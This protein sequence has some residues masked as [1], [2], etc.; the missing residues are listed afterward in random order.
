M[1]SNSRV[2]SSALLLIAIQGAS[3]PRLSLLWPCRRPHSPNDTLCCI[4]L[5]HRT[6]LSRTFP[7]SDAARWDGPPASIPRGDRRHRGG[8]TRRSD[9]EPAVSCPTTEYLA[10]LLG[11]SPGRIFEFCRHCSRRDQGEGGFIGQSSSK[12]CFRGVVKDG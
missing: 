10:E 3:A 11:V 9:E 1:H 7:T 5:Q 2:L 8:R 12:P 4:P 6:A